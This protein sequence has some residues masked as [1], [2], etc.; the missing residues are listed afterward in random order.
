[1]F[2]ETI[3]WIAVAI[4]NFY[5][6]IVGFIAACLGYFMPLRDMM[7]LIIFF[8]FIEMIVGYLAARK[9]R[10]ESFSKRIVFTKTFPRLGLVIFMML[11]TYLWDKV[12]SQEYIHTYSLLGW[13]V[14]GVL[15]VSI[16]KKGYDVTGWSPFKVI[17]SSIKSTIGTRIK[18]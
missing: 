7:H 10:G 18:A 8:F 17:S 11:G 5:N 9:L 6:W 1:M 2:N 12:F 14:C 16:F 15:L 13:F 4:T 3:R